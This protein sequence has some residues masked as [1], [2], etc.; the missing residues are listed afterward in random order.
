MNIVKQWKEGD[1]NFVWYG[2]YKTDSMADAM[3]DMILN[4]M[5][6]DLGPMAFIDVYEHGGYIVKLVYYDKDF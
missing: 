5:D 4:N 6:L 2:P 1:K 3:A